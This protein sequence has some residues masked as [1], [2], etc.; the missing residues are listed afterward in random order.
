L[1]EAVAGE[2]ESEVT[3][4]SLNGNATIVVRARASGPIEAERLESDLRIRA[5]E[6]LRAAGVFA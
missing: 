6:R 5:H 4:T 3:V 2:R 1:R